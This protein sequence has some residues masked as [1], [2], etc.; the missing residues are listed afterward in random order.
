MAEHDSNDKGQ[1]PGRDGAVKTAAELQQRLGRTVER[2]FP[3]AHA[4]DVRAWVQSQQLSK[5]G[6]SILDDWQAAGQVFVDA[7]LQK[8]N[9]A[10]ESANNIEKLAMS[11]QPFPLEALPP[12]I[13]E[14]VAAVAE[15][16]GCDH[17]LVA[18]PALAVCAGCIGNSRTIGLKNNWGEPAILWAAT[19][20]KSGTCK[21]PAFAAAVD[22]LYEIQ[23]ADPNKICLVTADSTVEGMALLLAA[24]PKGIELARD[25]LD[26]WF[27]ALSGRYRAGKSGATDRP[28]WLEFHRAGTVRID[29]KTSEPLTIRR[30]AVSVIGTIQ[31]SVLARAFDQ[32][33][34][35]AGLA[36]RFLLAFPAPTKRVW[37][38]ADVED[39]VQAEY[40]ELLRRLIYQLHLSDEERR[41]PVRLQLD[42]KAKARWVDW[43]NEWGE[44]QHT[45]EG[46]YAAALA[47]LEGYAACL[48]LI[49]HVVANAAQR[50]YGPAPISTSSLNAG[51]TL[52]EWFADEAR[53]VYSTLRETDE[54]RG[55]RDLVEW[56]QAH[57]GK[58]TVRQ[59][60]TS[61]SAKWPSS[62]SAEVALDDLA[63]HGLG[64]W[65]AVETPPHGGHRQRYFVLNEKRSDT[66][67]T[68]P[69]PGSSV[70]SVGGNFIV[71]LSLT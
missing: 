26:A 50:E 44:H 34:T 27:T 8:A 49:H 3:P 60:Q 19:I 57:G 31:P 51:I 63:Q 64:T 68:R 37:R 45:A 66:S 22:P 2:A 58:V 61:N 12:V 71:P 16:I 67:Y 9:T 30:A 7:V 42:E 56:I 18:L 40:A 17:S 28:H 55:R 13:K 11:N 10:P 4:K 62:D 70:G 5:V 39:H 48:A 36:A 59:L 15:A 35:G 14:F 25:E 24:N 47:K 41:I 1:W 46:E 54:E 6:E 20:G 43:F 29:R 53:R 32:D 52:A 33:A 21:S 23:A 69:P 38:D 65:H